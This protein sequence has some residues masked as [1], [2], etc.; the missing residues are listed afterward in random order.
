MSFKVAFIGAGSIGFTRTLLRDLLAVPEFADIEIAFT[1]ID[2]ANLEA[3]H[4]AGPK[5]YWAPTGSRSKSPPL[6]S[7]APPSPVLA[8]SFSLVRVGGLEAFAQDVEIPLRYGIDQCVGDTL[9]AGGIMYAQR[10]IPVV[11]EFC[12]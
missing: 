1:D 11:L 6:L 9:C 3:R 4:S 10:G 8:M 5:R 7:A 12:C 2:Q